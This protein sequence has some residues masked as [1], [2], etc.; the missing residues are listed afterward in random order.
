MPRHKYMARHEN[1]IDLDALEKAVGK[2][3][4]PSKENGIPEAISWDELLKPVS[5]ENNLIG[6]RFLERKCGMIIYGAAGSGKS[7]AAN[8]L[9]THF[10]A[11][12]KAF[13]LAPVRPL[14]IVIFQ[15]ED[16]LDD[17]RE[18]LAGILSAPDWT[19]ESRE[20]VKQ[21]L[22]IL[23]TIAGGSPSLLAGQLRQAAI[24]YKADL[25]SVNPLL[26]F[27]PGDPS[28]EL[29]GILYHF[30]DP[31]I[32]EMNVGFIG[33]HHTT[34]S[35]NRDTSQYGTHDWQYMA[36][37]DARVANWPRAM[38]SIEESSW[39]VYRFRIS[40][41]LATC[42]GGWDSKFFSHCKDA[43]R[44]I[45]ATEEQTTA[46]AKPK[47]SKQDLLPH[48]PT[49]GT[50]LKDSLLQRAIDAGIR[51]KRARAYLDELLSEAT[52]HLWLVKRRGTNPEKRIGRTAQPE[53]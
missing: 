35:N 1:R 48:V 13:H 53:T 2:P 43:V 37:G 32:K 40:K 3:E 30:I 6:D 34:K 23:P 18:F 20:L 50:I 45:D 49:T 47:N 12:L 10:A 4:E 14:R 11:G 39:P 28:K 44:W 52:L 41:R 9:L 25:L 7:V 24:K 42:G 38:I 26:A 15:T 31:V 46:A 19:S 17:T 29:G 27:C 22:V 8:Q 33:I 21:N 51:Q 5:Y 36:A 16:S